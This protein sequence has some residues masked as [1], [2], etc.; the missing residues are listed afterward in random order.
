[1]VGDLLAEFDRITDKLGVSVKVEVGK[2]V[3]VSVTD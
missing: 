3:D 2:T 1:L